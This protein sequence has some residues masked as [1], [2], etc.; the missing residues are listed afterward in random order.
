MDGFGDDLDGT[1]VSYCPDMCGTSAGSGFGLR[2]PGPDNLMSK[3][4]IIMRFSD[5][6][7][8]AA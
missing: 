6:H 4:D 8:P 1:A 5:L 7:S 3:S 2:A